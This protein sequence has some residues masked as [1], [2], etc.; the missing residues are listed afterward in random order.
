MYMY[1]VIFP[2]IGMFQ[3]CRK[4]ESKE[5][6]YLKNITQCTIFPLILTALGLTLDAGLEDC[7][8]TC[9]CWG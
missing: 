5:Q 3:H 9:C 4:R 6:S 1:R 7:N 2:T 8:F